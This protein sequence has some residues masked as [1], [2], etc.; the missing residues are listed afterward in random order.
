MQNW[1]TV[2]DGRVAG[3]AGSPLQAL[4]DLDGFD[5][6]AGRIGESA[7]RDYVREIVHRL[8]M[9]PGQS[10]FEIG[11]GSG[12]FLLPLR[13][14]GMHVAGLDYSSALIAAARRAI[15]DGDF[16]VAE[17]ADFTAASRSYDFIVAN[18]VFH[19]FPDDAYAERVLAE[20]LAAADKAVAILE[21]PDQARRSEAEAARRALLSKQEYET[22]YAGLAHRYYS[23]ETFRAAAQRRGFEAEISN[24]AIAGYAQNAFRFNCLMRRNETR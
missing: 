15:P 17:A 21:L 2:W 9:R 13:E 4:I 19:Y 18:S 8:G 1:K 16:R 11:C 3:K 20:M 22:K 14:A 12:A 7:W 24:Q 5:S 6:G 10:V 23:R